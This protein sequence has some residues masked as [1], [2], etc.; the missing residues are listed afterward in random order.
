[1]KIRINTRTN[2]ALCCGLVNTNRDR[3]R[4]CNYP[5]LRGAI[6]LKYF[7]N[8]SFT[9]GNKINKPIIFG[10]TKAKIIA[11]EKAHTEDISPAAPIT[12][13]N[14]NIN[15]YTISDTLLFPKIYIHDCN[16]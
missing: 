6:A 10:K 12:I 5:F 11:S 9:L 3:L 1:M 16:P 2:T 8:S 13:N 4:I 7:P 15:L 14:K